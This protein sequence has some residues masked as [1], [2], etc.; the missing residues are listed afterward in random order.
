MSSIADTYLDLLMKNHRGFMSDIINTYYTTKIQ[1]QIMTYFRIYFFYY[2]ITTYVYK[3]ELNIQEI[4]N[5]FLQWIVGSPSSITKILTE[6]YNY[7]FKIFFV[8][9]NIY[10]HS[11][12]NNLIKYFLPLPYEFNTY[13]TLITYRTNV[14]VFYKKNN[15]DY[16][17]SINSFDTIKSGFNSK[18]LDIHIPIKYFSTNIFNEID[19]IYLVGKKNNFYIVDKDLNV[20]YTREINI[21]S[22]YKKYLK[23]FF[24]RKSF[25]GI[26]PLWKKQEQKQKF[27]FNNS[28]Y[29]CVCKKFNCR[30]LFNV[31]NKYNLTMDKYKLLFH[32]VHMEYIKNSNA[33]L[34]NPTFFYLIP[35]TKSRY[36]KGEPRACVVFKINT[37]INNLLDLTSS[38]VSNNNFTRKY[39]ISD[40]ANKVWTSNNPNEV[41]SYYLENNIPQK[42]DNNFRCV[43]SDVEVVKNR[44]YCDT[45]EYAG[46]RKLQEIFFKTR[47]YKYNRIYWNSDKSVDSKFQYKI[48]H[49]KSQPISA[50]WDFDKFI[51][52]DIGS[53]G[54]FS[55]DYGDAIN[56]GELL[57]IEPN[58]YLTI[59]ADS[60]KP[61][62]D[63]DCFDS[64][65]ISVISEKIN[66]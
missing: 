18:E 39:L 23:E 65:K 47:K 30:D 51:L 44:I 35:I 66:K 61:C 33:L 41:L 27:D 38:I 43:N 59:I 28:I 7:L 24:N 31:F 21:V 20:L 56:G 13:F 29:I 26:F 37:P 4:K 17:E 16:F 34:I 54:F 2:L 9:K 62:F 15:Y 46:R 60:E 55:V 64:E 22:N 52:Q 3:P 58:K 6:E 5:V 19:V 8:E 45:F 53:N 1:D 12:F 25:E 63:K 14:K 49:R 50:N 48:Y 42:F 36:F 40:E 11:Y 32:N 57:L 10:F